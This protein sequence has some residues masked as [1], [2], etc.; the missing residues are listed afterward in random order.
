MGAPDI[1]G[2]PPQ[3]DAALRSLRGVMSGADQVLAMAMDGFRAN[4]RRQLYADAVARIADVMKVM[5]VELLA[6]LRDALG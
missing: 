2:V 6:P 3:V 4:V 5:G 1:A